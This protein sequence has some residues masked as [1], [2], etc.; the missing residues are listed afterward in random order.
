MAK[1]TSEITEL[2]EN[3][4]ILRTYVYHLEVK[5]NNLK[6]KTDDVRNQLIKI[7]NQVTVIIDG[8]DEAINRLD[9]QLK[10]HIE[11]SE[12]KICILEARLI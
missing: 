5:L 4:D 6:T 8:H 12:R 11:W 1:T 7:L 3:L 10:Q 2:K 9:T